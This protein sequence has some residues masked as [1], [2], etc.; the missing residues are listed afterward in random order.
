[1]RRTTKL[2]V[3][4]GL[5]TLV[6][7]LLFAWYSLELY[8]EEDLRAQHKSLE[9]CI[10]T[11]WEFLG[12]K[13][14]EFSI[15]DGRLLV[16]GHV[17]SGNP[18]VP[19]KVQEIFGGVAT[20]FMGD[21]RVST[22]VLD[23]K[24]KRAVG[25]RLVGPAYS[26]IFT[27]G[28]PYRGEATILGHPYL[29]AYDPIRDR[30]GLIIGAI[31]VGVEKSSF[32]EQFSHVKS[33]ILIVLAGLLA[34][35]A[36]VIF[37]LLQIAWRFE[38]TAVDALNFLRTLMDTIPSPIFY[39]DTKG[40]YLGLNK[41]YESYV[42]LPREDIIGK[43]GYDLWPKDLASRYEQMDLALFKFPGT[44]RYESSVAY[45]DGIRRD[46][47]FHKATFRA[48][49]GA[50]AGL[51]GIILDITERKQAHDSH[52]KTNRQLQ[53]IL[54][55][56]GE[57]IYGVDMQGNVTFINP[58][59]A[60][61]VGWHQEELLGKNQH[62]L[63][64]HT[65][66]DHTSYPVEDCP[67]HAAVRSGKVH[68]GK[69]ELYWRKDGTSFQVEYIS[70]PLRENGELVGAVVIFKDTTERHLAE[71]QLLK[72]SQA[73][74]QSPISVLIT[75]A[76]GKIEFVNPI[77]TKMSGYEAEEVVGR[78]LRLLM[79]GKTPS[80]VYRSILDTVTAGRVWTGE[81]FNRKKTV[82]PTGST[83]QSRRSG[84]VPVPSAIT[85]PPWK[86]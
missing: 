13:G 22:N 85:C 86:T 78:S 10:R 31:F 57:G 23:G 47:I 25:T 1:M 82:K 40:R 33:P 14:A 68:E 43:T 70:T 56:A 38:D 2:V 19:D 37:L 27:K 35:L 6:V 39:K 75:D 36:G 5:I 9:T 32:Q 73:V 46:V 80:E 16:G 59:A 20:I 26:A 17:V 51:V 81:I 7:L 8:Y 64:H 72:L 50:V 66:A 84:T 52:V 48:G 21:I 42:S 71:E 18:E 34:C 60:Q 11:F 15:V 54:D 61:M 49:D 79:D 62:S 4:N 53:L 29:T 12:H 55:A 69:D 28:R 58:A 83:P 24:G 3:S 44:Q 77:F 76:A 45:H 30:K 63:I 41:A 67:I 74:M 65:K